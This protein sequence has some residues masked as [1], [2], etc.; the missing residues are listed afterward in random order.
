MATIPRL[1][2][3]QAEFATAIFRPLGAADRM[4]S[5]WPDGRPTAQVVGDLIKPGPLL[6]SF[7]R[8][9]IYNRQY[10]FR[11]WDCLLD[12]YPGLLAVLGRRRFM[13]LATQY[14]VR[15]P[16]RSFTLRNL[17]RSLATHLASD[18]RWR[19]GLAPGRVRLVREMA[20]FEWAQVE[21]FD[22]A[23]RS[24]IELGALRGKDPATLRLSLQPSMSL[25]SL[26]WALDDFAIALKQDLQQEQA[27]QAS[28]PE[29]QPTRPRR[30]RLPRAERLFLAV[31]RVDNSLFYKRLS[32]PAF[33]T[34]R[35]LQAGATLA[36]AV[37]RGSAGLR[38]TALERAQAVQSWFATWSQLG[39]LCRHSTNQAPRQPARTP[40]RGN[41]VR[42]A[43][44]PRK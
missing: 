36:A 11:L 38:G 20:A 2:E 15:F 1:A 3:I 14:L 37:E 27:S 16:S 22:G 42:G 10:W 31:H 19:E 41:P 21:A 30:R 8:L 9:E 13:E 7:E 17:G 35:E 39:W 6:P 26:H 18:R 5:R 25:L 32:A 23:I 29:A 40:S 44:R 12:D 4:A 24:P 43:K 33:R 28:E 34:L